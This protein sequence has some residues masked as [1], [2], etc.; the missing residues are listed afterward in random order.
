MP[1]N[2]TDFIMQ[3]VSVILTVLRHWMHDFKTQNK[4]K[5]YMHF[6]LN[7][8]IMYLMPEDGQ[9]DW[10]M[11]RVLMELIKFVVVDSNFNIICYWHMLHTI[12]YL[13][14]VYL[15][16]GLCPRFYFMG[17]RFKNLVNRNQ[18]NGYL[19]WHSC[20][21]RWSLEET[22]HYFRGNCYLHFSVA[23]LS[24]VFILSC[25]FIINYILRLHW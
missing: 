5:M 14:T 20:H 25:Q 12:E 15:H 23:Y 18:T 2:T 7:F 24:A 17:Q 4:Y 22:F 1:S 9:Y 8:K 6:T 13:G 11:Y 21:W 3:H 10:N 19:S 16:T